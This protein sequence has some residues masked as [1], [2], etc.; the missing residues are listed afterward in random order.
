M[1]PLSSIL[2]PLRYPAAPCPY[3]LL[4]SSTEPTYAWWGGGMG[5]GHV[6]GTCGVGGV[7]KLRIKLLPPLKY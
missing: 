1:G 7:L 2:G 3:G 5:W 6:V 4:R